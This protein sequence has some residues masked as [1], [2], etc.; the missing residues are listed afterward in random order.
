MYTFVLPLQI[1]AEEQMERD[2]NINE[3]NVQE[4]GSSRADRTS[5]NERS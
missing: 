4:K 1:Q 5:R 3:M 2:Q